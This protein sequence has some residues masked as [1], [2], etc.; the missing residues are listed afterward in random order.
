MKWSTDI[1][2]LFGEWFLLMVM[3]LLIGLA[4]GWLV[5]YRALRKREVEK[6][7]IERELNSC[8]NEKEFIS[9]SRSE[10]LQAMKLKLQKCREEKLAAI[11]VKDEAMA[12]LKESLRL[13]EEAKVVEPVDEIPEAMDGLA[14][15]EAMADKPKVEE[16][17]E[18]VDHKQIEMF[19]ENAFE[20]Q[21]AEASKDI[22]VGY[23]DNL[24]EISGVGPKMEEMLK[25]FGVRTFYQLS[26]FDTEGM[27][28]LDEKIDGFHGR[29]ERDDWIGQAKILYE[30]LE[31][32][33]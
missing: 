17:I 9:L 28:V 30:Q 13:C 8:R 32:E 2:M 22:P 15:A 16:D 26:Q 25:D 4:I 12:E 6:E 23:E 24:K 10:E 19:F 5:W 3:P 7:V 18:L 33:E 1:L 27:A 11:Q 20:K 31:K 21:L 29:V 14:D